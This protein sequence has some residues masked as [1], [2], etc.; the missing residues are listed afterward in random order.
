MWYWC[1]IAVHVSNRSRG[2]PTGSATAGFMA[3]ICLEDSLTV[4]L[5]SFINDFAIDEG[6]LLPAQTWSDN[7]GTIPSGVESSIRNFQACEDALLG[8]FNMRV[9][10]DPKCAIKSSAVKWGNKIMTQFEEGSFKNRDKMYKMK[11][12][13]LLNL[14]KDRYG[15]NYRGKSFE[16]EI[17]DINRLNID[18]CHLVHLDGVRL[19]NF[20]DLM[21][22]N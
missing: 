7:L 4:A 19:S 11:L 15:S 9:K 21:L 16:Y 17:R 20:R 18:A 8:L 2:A 14:F 13:D 10:P 1:G 3:R 6:T 12:Q 5:L 22:Q